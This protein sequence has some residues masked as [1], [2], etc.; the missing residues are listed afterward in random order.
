MT[1][2]ATRLADDAILIAL[3][4]NLP[5]PRWGAPRETLTAALEALSSM[6]VRT[7]KLSRW[8]ATEPV[9]R[10][11]Q[12]W[13]TNAVARVGTSLEPAALLDRL[14]EVEAA[15][16]RERGLPNAA[17]LIDLDL[18]AHGRVVLAGPEGPIVPH[19]RLRGRAF[20]LLPLADV[21]P[22]WRHPATGEGVA[23]LIAA[24]PPDQ[25]CVPLGA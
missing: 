9:P 10:S 6:D 14:H 4:G 12:P 20:V 21:A 22:G 19:P 24:L 1:D 17:R 16:G 25:P 15:F 7:L 11:D 3:G 2:A 8:Y 5:S 23:E 18:I 13:F